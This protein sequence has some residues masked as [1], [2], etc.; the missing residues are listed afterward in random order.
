VVTALFEPICSDYQRVAEEVAAFPGEGLT[1]LDLVRRLPARSCGTSRT[2][3][4][5]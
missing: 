3:S 2:P 4:R 1:V 5:S